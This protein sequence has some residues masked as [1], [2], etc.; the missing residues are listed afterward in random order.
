MHRRGVAEP[1]GQIWPLGLIAPQKHKKRL[2]EFKGT[3]SNAFNHCKW[4]SLVIYDSK[5]TD[6]LFIESKAYRLL[7][8][9]DGSW[10]IVIGV[11]SLA[12]QKR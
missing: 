3:R 5:R 8:V 7:G 1:D 2:I 11:A 9:D 10:S 12:L 4:I 6:S